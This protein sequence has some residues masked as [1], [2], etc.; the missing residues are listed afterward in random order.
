MDIRI[1]TSARHIHLTVEDF[2]SLFGDIEPT[3]A[4]ELSQGDFSCEE[5]V[6]IVGP[7][8]SF[9]KV[10]LLVPFRD[11]SQLEIS[12]TDCYALGIDAPLKI[13]GDLPGSNVK[14]VGPFGSLEKNIAIV[15]KRHLHIPPNEA[16]K[17]SLSNDD[18][19]E[20]KTHGDRSL[21]LSNIIVRVKDTFKTAVHIDTDEA[22]AA[23][24]SADAIGELILNSQ[25]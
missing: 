24:I 2:K 11:Y 8:S 20:V 21:V 18:L 7:K 4:K 3:K 25:E 16:E 12:R 1:E 9:K 17:L 6:E 10:R 19:I 22:N 14:I 15:A 13:S 23:G 5:F